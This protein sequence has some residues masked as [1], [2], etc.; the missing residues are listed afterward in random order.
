M[1]ETIRKAI[2]VPVN[3]AGRPFIGGFA[4]AAL[5]L[6]MISGFLGILGLIATLWC[7]YFFRDPDRYTPVRSGLIVSG[8]DGIVS[9][10]E[11]AAPPAELGLP[12]RPL[13]RISVFLNVFDVHVNRLPIDGTIGAVRYRPGKFLNA[14]LDKASEDNERNAVR[15]D[16]PDGAVVVVQ[17][18]GLIARRIKCWIREGEAAKAGAR[19]GLIRFG[20]RVDVYLPEGVAA[21]VAPGQR[22][23]AGETVIADLRAQ[24]P[25][26]L[27]EVR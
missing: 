25:A 18:A 11:P 6:W 24:E 21:L 13:T 26:R 5:L 14:A 4:L 22:C 3:P 15:I 1:I 9:A 19:F 2:L 10:V 20:S 7:V 17:I 16:T 23:I 8:A 27:V 12:D